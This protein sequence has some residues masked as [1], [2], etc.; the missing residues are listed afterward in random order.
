MFTNRMRHSILGSER[1]SLRDGRRG[2]T[3]AII[4]RLIYARVKKEGFG[5]T[6]KD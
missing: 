6:I 4:K 2:K 1:K 3:L 5:G